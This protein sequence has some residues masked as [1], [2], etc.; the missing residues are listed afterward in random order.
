ML[1]SIG[2]DI[3]G[4]DY[5][6][7]LESEYVET[8]DLQCVSSCATGT[9]QILAPTKGDNVIVVVPGANSKSNDL[10]IDESIAVLEKLH[11]HTESPLRVLLCQNE[12]PIEG[13]A[14]MMRYCSNVLNMITIFNPAPVPASLSLLHTEREKE[15][16]RR[17]KKEREKEREREKEKERDKVKEKEREKEK[18]GEEAKER[19]KEKEREE[20]KE[21]EQAQMNEKESAPVFTPVRPPA[22][23]TNLTPVGTLKTPVDTRNI[24]SGSDGNAQITQDVQDISKSTNGIVLTNPNPNPN[25]NQGSSN[26]IKN[27]NARILSPSIERPPGKT[28]GKTNLLP[29][30][31]TGA[32]SVGPGLGSP[33]PQNEKATASD[34]NGKADDDGDIGEKVAE[35]TKHQ[36]S[37][38]QDGADQHEDGPQKQSS[39]GAGADA[40][41]DADAG[42]GAGAASNEVR[43]DVGHDNFYEL[44]RFSEVDILSPNQHEL[45]ALTGESDDCCGPT[46][47][48]LCLLMMKKSILTS[49]SSLLYLLLRFIY[50]SLSIFLLLA[51]PYLTIPLSSSSQVCQPN[52]RLTSSLQLIIWP[53]C[54]M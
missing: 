50:S 28:V 11:I 25:P 29:Q 54:A 37:N 20:A 26:N 49:P 4:K 44:M 14:N 32:E 24:R 21:K 12:I 43:Y 41:A 38:A 46:A 40:D 13:S 35:P 8:S 36:E 6:N 16:E 33:V 27:S 30:A 45:A 19:E 42:A 34:E 10:Y 53:T 9:A 51:L 52:P 39:A 3:F 7:H 1:G 23:K 17:Q 48:S 31:P 15:R 22:G 47:L 5:K 2:D 18:E